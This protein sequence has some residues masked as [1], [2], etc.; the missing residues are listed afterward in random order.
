MTSVSESI[1]HPMLVVPPQAER[2]PRIFKP[3]WNAPP[4]A[5]L[6]AFS[7]LDSARTVAGEVH[8]LLRQAGRGA[9]AQA[10]AEPGAGA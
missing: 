1:E 3:F 5:F 7:G 4:M 6:W 9:D 8:W 10:A 2:T